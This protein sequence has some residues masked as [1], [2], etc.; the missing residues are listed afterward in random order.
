MLLPSPCPCRPSSSCSSRG[1]YT[2]AAWQHGRPWDANT[3]AGLFQVGGASPS[4]KPSLEPPQHAA[5]RP[6]G[7][8][9]TFLNAQGVAEGKP[10]ESVSQ[11]G[12][13]S[14]T[15]LLELGQP[16]TLDPAPG[17]WG[18]PS[19]DADGVRG[20]APCPEN[21]AGGTEWGQG[22]RDTGMLTPTP[23][24][25][26]QLPAWTTAQHSAMLC[27]SVLP[28]SFP[29]SHGQCGEEERYPAGAWPRVL[30]HPHDAVGGGAA[31]FWG[32]GSP[33]WLGAHP[34]LLSTTP[35]QR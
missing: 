30:Q 35:R 19:W 6:A 29:L 31:Q 23:T 4:R 17:R 32:G 3:M 12:C 1:A 16:S 2:A 10:W 11:M 8:S 26:H 28:V 13:P 33:S 9:L 34:W 27:L 20:C 25:C 24:L 14:A 15:P 22:L 21:M 18:A 7:S 5:K